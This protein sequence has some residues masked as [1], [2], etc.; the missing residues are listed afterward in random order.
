MG[1]PSCVTSRWKR[2]LE[3]SRLLWRPWCPGGTNRRAGGVIGLRF[4][5]RSAIASVMTSGSP[6]VM[7]EEYANQAAPDQSRPRAGPC[8]GDQPAQHSRDQETE[9]DPGGEEAL[10]TRRARLRLRS[11]T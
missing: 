6:H 11:G 3:G 5:S 2:P 9:G 10:A 8:P 1:V 4:R 7:D